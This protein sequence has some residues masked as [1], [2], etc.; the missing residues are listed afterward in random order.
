ML[1]HGRGMKCC[2][3]SGS[4]TTWIGLS[5]AHGLAKERLTPWGV[6]HTSF[7][8]HLSVTLQSFAG[9][10]KWVTD[11]LHTAVSHTM[12]TRIS[13]DYKS[14]CGR[15]P[16]TS[17]AN[18]PIAPVN[19]DPCHYFN[20]WDHPKHIATNYPPSVHGSCLHSSSGPLTIGLAFKNK[21]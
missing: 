11:F 19:V 1:S 8:G 9:G 21:D 3:T 15:K 5:W 4:T 14:A 6:Y 7:H 12:S 17:G 16:Y 13:G 18:A 2:P 10:T 20:Y